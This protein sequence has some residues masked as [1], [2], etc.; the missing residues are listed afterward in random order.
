MSLYPSDRQEKCLGMAVII[1]SKKV[2]L[3]YNK[4]EIPFIIKLQSPSL[5]AQLTTATILAE[6]GPAQ[7]QLVFYLTVIFYT[8]TYK[9]VFP[10]ISFDENIGSLNAEIDRIFW[11]RIFEGQKP[12]EP[13]SITRNAL[14][15][16]VH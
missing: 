10:I 15:S 13:F 12:Q 7:L 14:E 4:I 16:D 5:F 8:P 9:E 3:N 2:C 1:K 11:Q 6:L